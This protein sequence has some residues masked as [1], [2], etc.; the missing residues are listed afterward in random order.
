MRLNQ[1]F[2]ELQDQIPWLPLIP[3]PTPIHRLLGL[4]KRF[5]MQ[6]FWV[7][8]E[9]LTHSVYGG[10]KVRNLEFIL[11]QAQ[12]NLRN[13]VLTVVPYGSN[14][15][16]ALSYHARA[17]GIEVNLSQFVVFKNPQIVA[18]AEFAASQGAH[19]QNFPGKWA[20]PI[21]I[22]NAGALQIQEFLRKGQFAHWI[23]AG[24]SD[25]TGALGHFQAFFELYDQCREQSVPFPEE[26]IVGA[27]TCGTI[28]GLLA[29]SIALASFK[30]GSSPAQITGVKAADAIVC[31]PIRIARLASAV[32]RKIGVH[33]KVTPEMVRLRKCPGHVGYGIPTRDALRIINIFENEDEIP[34]DTTYTAKVGLYL[35]SVLQ[36]SEYQNKN[37]LYWHTYSPNAYRWGQRQKLEIAKQRDLESSD[38]KLS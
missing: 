5:G 36:S 9:D 25:A 33:K 14:F 12:R 17:L 7:K 38:T 24:A 1:Y 6:S 34:L 31:N 27:G 19:L 23:P 18:H 35:E 4:E 21:A 32:L 8:R 16:G 37:V 2:P 11:A 13:S 28:S 3:N 15:T 22:L 29:A 26:I 30:S 20:A 10:N